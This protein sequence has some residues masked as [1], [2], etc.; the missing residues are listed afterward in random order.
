MK[1]NVKIKFLFYSSLFFMDIENI[2]AVDRK[3]NSTSEQVLSDSI[4][5]GHFFQMF[6]GLLLVIILIFGLAWL[7]KR[8]NNF[9]GGMNDV[10]KILSIISVGQREKVVLIQVG[11]QQLLIGVSTGMVNTLLVLDEVVEN[12]VSDNNQV[13]FSE[14]LSTVLKGRSR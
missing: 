8:I 6:F 14:R 11:E 12:K 3:L 7:I 10:L 4:S 13:S 1:L 9:Q 5:T 2:F